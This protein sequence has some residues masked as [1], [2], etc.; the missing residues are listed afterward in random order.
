MCA[1]QDRIQLTGQLDA[2]RTNKRYEDPN[3]R[4]CF[5]APKEER[6]TDYSC[7]EEVGLN[8]VVLEGQ[9]ELWLFEQR[10]PS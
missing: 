8:D 6:M 7:E 5:T 2:T 10:E 3:F 4:R 9:S 1:I